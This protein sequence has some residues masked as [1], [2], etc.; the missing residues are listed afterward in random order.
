MTRRQLAFL[1]FLISAFLVTWALFYG[2]TDPRLGLAALGVT[3]LIVAAW[4][5]LFRAS[6]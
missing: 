6:N 4:G 3:F 2:T 1:G 5:W